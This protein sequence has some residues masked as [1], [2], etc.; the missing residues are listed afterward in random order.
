MIPSVDPSVGVEIRS[1]A[2]DEPHCARCG[3]GH[4]DAH[5]DL[6]DLRRAR[7]QFDQLWIREAMGGQRADPFTPPPDTRLLGPDVLAA[8]HQALRVCAVCGGSICEEC[9]DPDRGR[10]LDCLTLAG[11]V[12]VSR[13]VGPRAYV[14]IVPVSRPRASAPI[15][16]TH[17][18]AL[19]TGEQLTRA[20]DEIIRGIKSYRFMRRLVLPAAGG[21]A[22]AALIVLGSYF[23]R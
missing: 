5:L 3:R 13:A 2:E 9:W 6:G 11:P 7:L 15:S 21:V 19:T 4:P 22:L 12:S 20:M 1:L 17:P 23:V 14:G 16:S 8:V 10:C 18:A